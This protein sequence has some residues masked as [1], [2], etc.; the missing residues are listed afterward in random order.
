[1]QCCGSGMIY[2]GF[3]SGSSFEFSEFQIRIQA[4][5]SDPYGSGSGS[6]PYYLCTLYLEINKNTHLK[7]NQKE[8]STKY[9]LVLQYTQFRI[10]REITFLFICFSYL[11]ILSAIFNFTLHTVLQYTQSTAV[12]NTRAQN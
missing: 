6:K 10:H 2:S 8:E 7:F 5:V 12:Q 4:K 1:M 9:L 11:H 3:G